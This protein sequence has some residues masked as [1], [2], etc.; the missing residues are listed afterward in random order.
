MLEVAVKV[1]FL[2]EL[3]RE[4]ASH[5]IDEYVLYSY[6][7]AEELLRKTP[8][9]RAR[10][11]PAYYG[12]VG[13]HS[14]SHVVRVRTPSP[15]NHRGALVGN[16]KVCARTTSHHERVDS[17]RIT[18][19]ATDP[20]R[21][22]S[23]G[24]RRPNLLHAWAALGGEIVGASDV[25]KNPE[26]RLDCRRAIF[27]ST[28]AATR[29]HDVYNVRKQ[30][31]APRQYP[32]CFLMSYEFEGSTAPFDF[33][34]VWTYRAEDLRDCA[35][36]ASRLHGSYVVS[37]GATCTQHGYHDR[38]AAAASYAMREYDADGAFVRAVPPD[39]RYLEDADGVRR[40]RFGGLGVPEGGKLVL[41][42][43]LCLATTQDFADPD[44]DVVRIM[45]AM[46][47]DERVRINHYKEWALLWNSDVE[48]DARTSISA[49]E[50]ANVN[51][52]RQYHKVNLYTLYSTVRTD[53]REGFEPMNVMFIDEYG[54]TS[55][56]AEWHLLPVL[57]ITNPALA[58]ILLDHRF[59][60]LEIGKRDA[61]SMGHRGARMP[62]VPDEIESDSIYSRT[63][64]MHLH[65]TALVGIH[66]WNY[67]R[68]TTDREWLL[69]RGYKI[70]KH[71][72]RYM[73]DQLVITRDEQGRIVDIAL[74]EAA[75]IDNRIR[76]N[77]TL[78]VYATYVLLTFTLEATY[79]L[80]YSLVNFPD[81][82]DIH[83]YFKTALKAPE[84]LG[85]HVEVNLIEQ[86]SE[87][88]EEPEAEEPEA[89]AIATPVHT[90]T[91]GNLA[92]PTTVRIRVSNMTLYLDDMTT[93]PPTPLG[94]MFG[95]NS[96]FKLKVD[97][98]S[99]YTFELDDT[100]PVE[101]FDEYMNRISA[102]MLLPEST[103]VY[104]SV[105]NRGYHSGNVVV[106]GAAIRS[107]SSVAAHTVFGIHAFTTDDRNTSFS[108]VIFPYA[109]YAPMD[110]VG[111]A[112][113]MIMLSNYYSRAVYS[114]MV[115][116]PIGRAGAMLRDNANYY[117]V[118][119]DMSRAFNRLSYANLYA[120][121]AQREYSYAVR[122]ADIHTYDV[123]MLRHFEQST[124]KP[125]GEDPDYPIGLFT[126]IDG[127]AGLSVSGRVNAARY[128]VEK[129]SV[130]SHNASVLPEY[131]KE[132]RI[133]THENARGRRLYTVTN[134]M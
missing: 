76:K 34:H 122:R 118:V 15:Y 58:K 108:H 24:H 82:L 67:F 42:V 71:C 31:L 97:P 85:N 37:A 44:A 32:H 100:H 65:S 64:G 123:T 75:D 126:V 134:V 57:V 61:Q 36:V 50:H 102:S 1:V 70:M 104:N 84:S 63:H 121:V 111:R 128:Y 92:L 132:L 30:V 113:P 124:F 12:E 89:S 116:N 131:W 17:M 115:L 62:F 29:H 129:Y 74:S 69:S 112:E 106:M 10:H 25:V 80:N 38:I 43:H 98:E 14:G 94:F 16:G 2:R 59:A 83:K 86:P 77:L 13:Y 21:T 48:I 88:A 23:T 8:E 95:G 40:V 103:A 81:W 91:T 53:A 56:D 60:Q 55:W 35:F 79:E 49:E 19:R 22:K 93:D 105:V 28:Y 130:S 7:R 110:S 11:D 54:D 47:A 68:R 99:T 90:F 26:Q 96:G 45:L 73:L 27:E 107:Y 109:G 117:H 52:H 87:E 66:A 127:I 4:P 39:P 101:F 46:L 119:A 78:V 125:W 5:E 20:T 33:D 120:S 51:R 114:H 41:D 3:G 72:T 18:Y 133:Y 9:Y 6:E